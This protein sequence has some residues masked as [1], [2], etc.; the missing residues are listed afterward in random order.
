MVYRTN[1]NVILHLVIISYDLWCQLPFSKK[2]FCHKGS[3]VFGKMPKMCR[4]CP[5]VNKCWGTGTAI[6]RRRPFMSIKSFVQHSGRQEMVSQCWLI[7]LI[8]VCVDGDQPEFLCSC[9]D[10]RYLVTTVTSNHLPR[11]HRESPWGDEKL[12]DTL[13]AEAGRKWK[14]LN[15][16]IFPQWHHTNLTAY[17]RL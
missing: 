11:P 2:T 4:G 1:I 6:L 5:D 13:T 14:M 7:R 12:S 17:Q 3:T 16:E 10:S 15:F 9:S 8:G